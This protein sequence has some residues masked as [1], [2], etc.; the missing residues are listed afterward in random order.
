M[1]RMPVLLLTVTAD[2]EYYQVVSL[3]SLYTRLGLKACAVSS[4]MTTCGLV[5]W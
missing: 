4:D 3:E 1:R 2:A 5:L